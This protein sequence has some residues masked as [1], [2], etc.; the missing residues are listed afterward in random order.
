MKTK[1]YFN[2]YKEI[3]E[4]K[5][6]EQKWLIWGK[7]LGKKGFSTEET[8]IKE[9]MEYLHCS[10]KELMKSWG[11]KGTKKIKEKWLLDNPK[12]EEQLINYYNSLDLYIPEL[13]SWHSDNVELFV[14]IVEFLQICVKN[15]LSLFLDYG[16]GIGSNGILFSK[17]SFKITLADISDTM[18]NYARWRLAR[19]KVY[20]EFI[21]LKLDT[22]PP[23][24]FDCATAIEVLE[25]TL[26]PI[27]VM[28]QIADSLKK[29]GYVFVTAPFYFDPERP[30]HIIH[31]MNIADKFEDL[32]LVL[33][34]KSKN[35]LYRIY[36][37]I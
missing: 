6:P 36:K 18:L 10:R 7:A 33:I 2:N 9:N 12:T 21:D 37:K 23:Q 15:K 3:L 30:Q 27:L 16:A 14:K 20:A 24:S 29:G 26:D 35:G 4:A 11:R 5:S 13:S 17:Y 1:K 34:S 25:H 28:K 8:L 31:D 22:I 32:G 19:H